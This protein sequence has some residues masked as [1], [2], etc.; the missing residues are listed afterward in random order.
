MIEL[1]EFEPTIDSSENESLAALP[2]DGASCVSAVSKLLSDPDKLKRA[3]SPLEPEVPSD[4][5]DLLKVRRAMGRP[6]G[7]H[8]FY[9]QNN[10][11]QK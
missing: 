7:A 3:I 8:V 5:Y 1:I 10:H 11:G 6:N 4:P 2:M 9:Y